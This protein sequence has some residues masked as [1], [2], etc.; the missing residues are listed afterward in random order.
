MTLWSNSVLLQQ[1]TS[2]IYKVFK[3]RI[4]CSMHSRSPI[5]LY[6]QPPFSPHQT[7]AEPP[8]DESDFPP[9]RIGKEVSTSENPTHPILTSSDPGTALWWIGFPTFPDPSRWCEHTWHSYPWY[10]SILIP[11]A[12]RLTHHQISRL[13]VN[14]QACL[15]HISNCLTKASD[16]RICSI[17]LMWLGSNPR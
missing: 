11:L 3:I 4:K 14:M 10:P 15:L 2:N 1:A 13:S 12:F 6:P 8:S 9:C 5:P 16:V 17:P 7:Q